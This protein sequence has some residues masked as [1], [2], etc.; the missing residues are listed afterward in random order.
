[1][2]SVDGALYSSADEGLV[3]IDPQSGTGILIGD[4]G[5]QS[6]FGLEADLDAQMYAGVDGGSRR[7]ASWYSVDK[8]TGRSILIGA[9][10]KS[11]GLGLNGLTFASAHPPGDLDRDGNVDLKDIAGFQACFSGQ[12][13]GPL[14]PEC[15]ISDLNLDQRVN[16]D[17]YRVVAQHLK[18]P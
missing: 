8:R 15:V 6:V 11:A 5:I 18:S 14:P 9:I 2:S 12:R 1:V 7:E 3:R 16:L 13:P 4:M 10:H 17:D